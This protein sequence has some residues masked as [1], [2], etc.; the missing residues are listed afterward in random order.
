MKF[1]CKRKSKKCCKMQT[2]CK[3]MK[4][5]Y[6]K[7]NTQETILL[8]NIITDQDFITWW[9]SFQFSYVWAISYMSSKQ[10]C[11]VHVFV[12]LNWLWILFYF[13]VLSKLKHIEEGTEG[14]RTDVVSFLLASQCY[15]SFN[16]LP[17]LN[18]VNHDWS[19]L[20]DNWKSDCFV[21]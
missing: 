11:Y 15:F 8:Y 1:Y 14:F 10:G 7:T 5:R 13:L 16:Y 17:W 2:N 12:F 4:H 3:K 20:I 19:P 6:P 18:A 9:Q 21:L